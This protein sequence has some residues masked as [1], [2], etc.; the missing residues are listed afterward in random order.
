MQDPIVA[1]VQA[2]LERRSAKGQAEYGAPLTR[3]DYALK[4]WLREAYEEALDHA[5]YLKAAITKM[6][7]DE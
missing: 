4:D 7:A 3:P 1:A 5:L 6:E 2:D